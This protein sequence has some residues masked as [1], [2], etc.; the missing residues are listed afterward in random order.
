LTGELRSHSS[1]HHDLS[2]FKGRDVVGGARESTPETVAL[3]NEAQ[4][5]VSLLVRG[6]SVD[7]RGVNVQLLMKRRRT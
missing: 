3:L 7:F 6:A 5:K 2:D 1:A 4:A